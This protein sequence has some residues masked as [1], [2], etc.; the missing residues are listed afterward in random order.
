ML[1]TIEW[2][3]A[4][5]GLWGVFLGFRQRRET[6][7]AWLASS[8]IYL[9]LTWHWA[10]Y[11]QSMV[12]LAFSLTAVWGYQQWSQSQRL[13]VVRPTVRFVWGS[14]LVGAG[15]AWVLAEALA[16]IGGAAALL[17]SVVAAGSLLAM[18]WTARR[19]RACWGIWLAVNLLSAWLYAG[20]GAWPTVLLYLVQAGLSVAGFARWTAHAR[21]QEA[22]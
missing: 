17:D 2:A 11:G 22:S 8:L 15:L 19:H 16:A 21:V 5:L 1:L 6:W 20:Q 7:L 3:A 9:L 12:M 10:L 18:V 4:A 14:L 13:E